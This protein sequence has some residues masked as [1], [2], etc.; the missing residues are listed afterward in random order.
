MEI[1]DLTIIGGGPT[2]LA[3]A[4]RAGM[5]EISA[6]IVETAPHLGGQ[7]TALY[8]EKNIYDVFGM[9]EVLGKDLV[10]N[11]TRQALQFGVD[12]HLSEEVKMLALHN[13]EKLIDVVT[14]HKVHQTRTVLLAGGLGL[15][16]PRKHDAEGCHRLEGHGVHYGV[17]DPELFRGENVVIVGGGDSALDWVL[18]LMPIAL[19][20]TVVHRSE[21]F[22]AHASTLR[23]VQQ[24]ADHG[25]VGLHTSTLL[26]AAHGN[27]CLEAVTLQDSRGVERRLE[28]QALLPMIGFHIN[29]GAMENWGLDFDDKKIVVN[30]RMETNLPGVFAAG[31]M[32]TY[33]G[34][35]KLIATGFAE[36]AIAVRS[37]V[38]YVRPGQKVRVQY[39][40][41][42]GVP[43][44]RLEI[45]SSS[46]LKSDAETA[47]SS[48]FA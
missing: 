26:R 38:E 28:A 45:Y 24:L 14:N 39:S 47:F 10:R 7:V 15:I 6:R 5:H 27:G 48:K 1:R 2:G 8:P 44:P 37:A 23:Q 42:A 11:L 41:I 35:I 20:V 21:E 16:T 22:Q 46:A 29:L 12:V 34:K 17:R 18:N 13:E 33:P 43:K 36:A 32:V 4:F 25:R 30:S 9:P 31:D 19:R 3:G 40:S